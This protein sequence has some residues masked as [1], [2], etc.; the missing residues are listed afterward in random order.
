MWMCMAFG[1]PLVGYWLMVI[2]IRAY[3]LSLRRALV[4]VARAVTPGTPYWARRDEPQ[5]LVALELR[6]PCTEQEVLAAYRKLVKDLHPD[7]GGDLQAFLK[8]QRYF[9]QAISLVR[10]QGRPG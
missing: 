1:L 10:Q 3:L 5:C 8:L 7:R 4:V 9:E 6:L 2:D